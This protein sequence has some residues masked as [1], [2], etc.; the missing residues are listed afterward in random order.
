MIESTN[1]TIVGI[2]TF[3]VVPELSTFPEEFLKSYFMRGYE[4]YFLDDDP[5][6]PLEMKIHVLF[7]IFPQLILFF[8]IDR[9]IRGVDWPVFIAGIQRKYGDRAMIGVMYHKRNNPEE[10]RKLEHLYLYTI[11][12]VCGCIAVSYQK[13][14]NLNLVMNVLAA[15]QANGQRKYL[16]A[17]CDDTY[18]ANMD[19]HGASYRC[20]LRDISISH[21]SCVFVGK[22][23]E[24]ALME[25]VSGIQM[26]LRGIILQVDGVL[27]LKR[28]M[29]QDMINVFVFRAEDGR[30]GLNQEHLR[31]VNDLIFHSLSTKINDLLR[32][33]YDAVRGQLVKNRK[34]K[35][36]TEPAPP[37][38]TLDDPEEELE[39]ID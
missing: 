20:T 30:E 4:T 24:I 22:A 7:S 19:Y 16:R 25:R 34:T 36:A 13:S 29:K 37:A 38:E 5:Y 8:N 12:I 33:E 3:F 14:K 28:V 39:G 32:K 15:N 35:G 26:N 31:K 27:C 11:G 1:E 9:P 21:F 23:P 2:K 10:V 6:C 17:I 18:K